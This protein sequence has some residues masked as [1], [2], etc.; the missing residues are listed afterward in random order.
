MEIKILLCDDHKIFREGLKTLL[1]STPRLKVVGEA[2][3]GRQSVA[4]AASLRPDIVV[5]DISMLV[6]VL[7]FL[8][9]T[10]AI[11]RRMQRFIRNA[12]QRKIGRA[13]V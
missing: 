1:A 5:M 13:H 2:A 8:G 7:L 10:A 6:F 3:D 9:L 11:S 4:L 12:Q